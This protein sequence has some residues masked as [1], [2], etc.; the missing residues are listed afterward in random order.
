M[1]CVKL[2]L[3]ETFFDKAAGLC[4][5][6]NGR[7]DDEFTKPNNVIVSINVFNFEPYIFLLYIKIVIYLGYR[8]LFARLFQ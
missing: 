1:H 8:L 2:Y 7:I 5:T 3:P 6:F 4:G